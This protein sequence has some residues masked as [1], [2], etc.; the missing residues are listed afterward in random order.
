MLIHVSL[1]IIGLGVLV[2]AAEFLVRGA[3]SLARKIGVKPLVIGLTAVAF[4]TSMPELVVNIYSAFRGTA[5]IAIGNVIGSNIANILLILG[6]SAAIVPLIVKHS[7]VWKEV[8]LALLAMVLVFFMGNDIWL[9]G[10][11]RDL[12]SR[13]DGFLLISVFIIFLYYTFGMAK[14]DAD[15]E[16]SGNVRIYKNK[17]SI[18][19]MV[20]GIVGLYLGG[21][22][23]VDQAVIMA[24]LAGMSEALIG[25]TIVAVG[26]SLPELATSVVAAVHRQSDLAVGNIVGSNIFNVFWILGLTSTILPLSFNAAVNTD[27]A[28]GIGA[29]FLLFL[30]MFVGQR[31]KLERWQGILFIL[32]Y[33]SYLAY[34][35]VRG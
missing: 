26:T 7:T 14:A 17:Y 20:A 27:V 30:A 5:D 18:I 21:K 2:L 23:L 15:S 9:D 1:L 16:A 31:H 28:V 11:S 4:G 10:A 19:F 22:L 33:F 24:R 3:S 29:T 6:L 32:L 13:T 8:P 25:L 12:L 34:I 35:V